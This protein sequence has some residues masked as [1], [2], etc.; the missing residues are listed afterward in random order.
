M[1]FLAGQAEPC[2][3]SPALPVVSTIVTATTAVAGAAA[4][5]AAA[6]RR[7]ARSST[8]T[9]RTTP[10]R[11]GSGGS[12][13]LIAGGATIAQRRVIESTDDPW[14]PEQL[15]DR[16][17]ALVSIPHPREPVVAVRGRP[18]SSRGDGRGSRWAEI[19]HPVDMEEHRGGNPPPAEGARALAG[20][21]RRDGMGGLSPAGGGD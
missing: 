12:C 11:T 3:G 7:S 4:S 10:V 16:K 8:A 6:S 2:S 14:I 13:V 17:G 15:A 9:S 18:V 20:K 21:V 5:V 1:A 19:D